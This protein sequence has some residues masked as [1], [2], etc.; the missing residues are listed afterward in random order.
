MSQLICG[1]W[2]CRLRAWCAPISSVCTVYGGAHCWGP[3]RPRCARSGEVCPSAAPRNWYWPVQICACARCK[4]SVQG[5]AESRCLRAAQILRSPLNDQR[6]NDVSPLICGVWRCRLRAWCAPRSAVSSTCTVGLT[7]GVPP[8]LV[9]RARVRSAAPRNYDGK[10]RAVRV[11][12]AESF[13][14]ECAESLCL[15]AVQIL[16]GDCVSCTRKPR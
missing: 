1:V 10:C 11:C 8:G 6:C 9:S 4:N 7:A 5:C 13:L 16:L 2:R 12:G 15:S 3:A 14:H